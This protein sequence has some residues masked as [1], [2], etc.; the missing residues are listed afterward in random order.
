MKNKTLQD[1]IFFKKSERVFFLIEIS[2]K[3]KDVFDVMIMSTTID[4]DDKQG[5]ASYDVG[6]LPFFNNASQRS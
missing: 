4:Y 2:K 3:K 6:W 1:F 5:K